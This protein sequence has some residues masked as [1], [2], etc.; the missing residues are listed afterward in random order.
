MTYLL[1][2]KRSK[3]ILQTTETVELWERDVSKN[4]DED[5]KIGVILA[6]APPHV[7]NRCHLNSYILKRYAQVWT[8]QFDYCRAQ[9]DTVAGDAVPLDLSVLG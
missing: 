8:M 5:V 1:Q 4:L 3:S 2:L 9:A 6:L 7:Q